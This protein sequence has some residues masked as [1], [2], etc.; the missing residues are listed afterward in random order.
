MPAIKPLEIMDA[1]TL[2]HEPQRKVPQL[3]E[4]LLPQGLNILCGA[5][6]IGKSWLMLWLCLQITKGDLVW[7]RESTR[8]D[9]LYLSTHAY[10]NACTA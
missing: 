1:E 9:A 8:A 7:G 6:K 3:I 4:G 5:S 2:Y 10:R